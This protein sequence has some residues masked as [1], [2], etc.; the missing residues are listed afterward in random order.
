[1]GCVEWACIGGAWEW[2][3]MVWP[4]ERYNFCS[5]PKLARTEIL[6]YEFLHRTTRA[7]GAGGACVE[8]E[9]GWRGGCVGVGECRCVGEGAVLIPT[10]SPHEL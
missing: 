2:A 6:G 5:G 3:R 1:M 4:S 9:R 10:G 8:G 7:Q